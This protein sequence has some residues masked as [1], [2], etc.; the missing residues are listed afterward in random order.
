M[1]NHNKPESYPNIFRLKAERLLKWNPLKTGSQFF[2]ANNLKLMNELEIYPIDLKIQNRE[3]KMSKAHTAEL[4]TELEED[5][6]HPHEGRF[7]SI[8]QDNHSV[9]LLLDRDSG[10]IKNA[11]PASK[12]LFLRIPFES[13]IDRHINIKIGVAIYCAM[14]ECINNM[15]KYL[16]TNSITIVLND[17]WHLRRLQCSDHSIGFD[18]TETPSLQKGLGFIT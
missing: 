16:Q 1:K 14:I 15:S 4:A 9:T 18:L 7:K 17:L 5:A 13:K 12:L 8:P 2:E 11:N 10:E 3:L 6:L